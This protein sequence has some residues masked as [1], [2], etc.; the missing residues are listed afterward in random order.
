MC[1]YLEIYLAC[2]QEPEQDP[3][4]RKIP[5]CQCQSRKLLRKKSGKTPEQHGARI[6]QAEQRLRDVDGYGVKSDDAQ[7]Q[8][9]L[10]ASLQVD[11]P[12]EERE[13]R[14]GIPAKD[15]RE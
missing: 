2:V 1:L 11:E 5:D 8:R 10:P 6:P 12:V 4:Y 14:D 3:A 13:H 7:E 9:P 15:Q